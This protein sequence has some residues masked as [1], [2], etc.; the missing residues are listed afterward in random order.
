MNFIICY[1]FINSLYNHFLFSLIVNFNIIHL[2]YF[3][4]LDF[5]L[6]YYFLLFDYYYYKF[7]FI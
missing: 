5:N 3:K 4:F 2:N 7:H 1:L 6:N